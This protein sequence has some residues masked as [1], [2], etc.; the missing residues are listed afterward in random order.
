LDTAL[1]FREMRSSSIHQD[2]GKHPT[3]QEIFTRPWSNPT[4]GGQTPQLRET[5]TIQPAEGR[6]KHNKI[7]KMK[8]YRNM[9]QVKEHGKTHQT[10]Q[11]KKR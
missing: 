2:T 7:N 11:M 4:H 8:R 1:P 10:R 6:S 5:T 3:N 9:Q